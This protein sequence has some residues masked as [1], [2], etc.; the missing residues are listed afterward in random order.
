MASRHG[1]GVARSWAVTLVLATLVAMTVADRLLY[2]A[3]V[4]AIV[5]RVDGALALDGSEVTLSTPYPFL[6]QWMSGS[7]RSISI[8]A[9]SFSTGGARFVDVTGSASGVGLHEPFVIDALD[10][11]ATLT[12]SELEDL[13][14]RRCHLS[15]SLS[16]SDGALLVQRAGAADTE[17]KLRA[18]GGVLV[19]ESSSAD[20]GSPDAL[21]D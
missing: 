3:Y 10:L 4:P 21:P 16:E 17:I 2:R 6:P 15:V 12:F 18:R 8:D 14:D 1:R 7:L 19:L 5:E 9:D 13:I 20:P 11:G